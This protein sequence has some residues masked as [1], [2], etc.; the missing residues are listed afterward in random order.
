MSIRDLLKGLL[1]PL[2]AKRLNATAALSMARLWIGSGGAVENQTIQLPECA[3]DGFVPPLT[4]APT[5]TP[6]PMPAR[7]CKRRTYC[8]RLC[9]AGLDLD[10][11]SKKYKVCHLRCARHLNKFNSSFDKYCQV[12]V[13]PAFPAL[14]SIASLPGGSG[15]E[16]AYIDSRGQGTQSML[17]LGSGQL[18]TTAASAVEITGAAAQSVRLGMC[19]KPCEYCN[20][21]CSVLGD[22]V[23]LP[24]CTQTC[25]DRW[26][27]TKDIFEDFCNH[28]VC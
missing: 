25:E 2:P 10:A 8:T 9:G 19:L 24:P 18:S 5:P 13:C 14:T 7:S 22:K 1:D 3:G 11:S 21:I 4:P 27:V 16:L 12:G 6:A 20:A 17:H 23:Y 28:G 15:K 26:R